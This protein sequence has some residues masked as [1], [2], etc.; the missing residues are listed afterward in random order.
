MA[1]KLGDPDL[2]IAY[3]VGPD[4][5]VDAS[6]CP[7][8]TPTPGGGAAVTR[9]DLAGSE[10]ALSHRRG[11]LENP[12]LVPG[13]GQAMHLSLD[14]ERLHA[15]GL[16]QLADLWASR[17]R[18]I[19]AGDRRRRSLERDLHDGAQQH[20]VGVLL[21][22]RL[23]RSHADDP[24]LRQVEADLRGAI[25]DLRELARGIFPVVLG[26]EGL[27]AALGALSETKH[28]KVT[29][30]PRVRLPAAVETT[31]YLIVARAVA[32]GPATVAAT[33]NQHQLVLE[34]QTRAELRQ[35]G[36][37]EDRIS[38]L[39]GTL[40]RSAAA[41]GGSRLRVV[42]PTATS[43]PTSGASSGSSLNGSRDWPRGTAR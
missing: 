3:R 6:A 7:V 34:V 23:L 32:T 16:T 35:L 30:A 22:L 31:A 33:E 8:G 26:D 11:L 17:A 38:A 1:A 10:A 43:D 40:V 25:E 13:L 24:E 15:L 14:N 39:G 36:E 12:D 20:L 21:A 19:D 42:L 27:A 9:I 4:R 29:S 18:I 41:A 28:R 5:W 37:I 2:R